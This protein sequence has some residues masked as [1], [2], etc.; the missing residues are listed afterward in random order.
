MDH[1][2]TPSYTV[3]VSVSDGMDDYSNTDTAEDANIEVT[4][5]VTDMVVPAVPSDQP[6]VDAASGAAAKLDVSW[7]AIA[8]TTTAPSMGMTCSTG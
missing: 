3:T 2:T 1:E 6:T 8:A 4:I 5:S 7:T